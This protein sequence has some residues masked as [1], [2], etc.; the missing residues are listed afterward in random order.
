TADFGRRLAL[1]Q[2]IEIL[3]PVGVAARTAA[4]VADIRDFRHLHGGLQPGHFRAD[5]PALRQSAVLLRIPDPDRAAA[6]APADHRTVP[7]GLV[8]GVAISARLAVRTAVGA[9][10]P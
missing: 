9:P 6:T 2:G 10:A 1:R 4:T 7:G 3:G 8:A 5:R